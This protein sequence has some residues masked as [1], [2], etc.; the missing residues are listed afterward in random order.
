MKCNRCQ[1][2]TDRSHKLCDV[3]RKHRRE[4]NITRKHRN[5][6]AG[7][8]ACGAVP[9][10]PLKSC[11]RCRTKSNIRQLKNY[12][13]STQRARLQTN[14]K[15]SYER[16]KT[17]RRQ[18]ALLY[19]QKNLFAIR[20]R[21][22][23]HRLTNRLII[24]DH[25]GGRI[26]LHCSE[27][28]LAA[29]TIDH[30][31]QNGAACRLIHGQT[32][33]FYRW[34][35]KNDFPLGYRVLCYNCNLIAWRQFQQTKL[36]PELARHRYYDQT[37]KRKLMDVLGGRCKKCNITNLV[38]L[39]IHHTNNNGAD[40]RQTISHG[41]SGSKFYRAVLRTNDFS[42]LECYCMNC[43]EVARYQSYPDNE[44]SR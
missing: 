24:L 35:I 8:C 7:L 34:L 9:D 12:A 27:T 38:I 19:R 6:S 22:R 43:N 4:V 37:L 15:K 5:V 44:L 21:E 18:A 23:R 36:K 14:N 40:H 16:N 11:T 28:R 31:D 26:C 13:D 20:D 33:K 39:T 42:G 1:R 32:E 10:S 2:D 25:Y 17:A 29:L 41:Y 3:C 30:I